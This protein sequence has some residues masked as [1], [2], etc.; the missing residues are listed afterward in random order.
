[1]AALTETEARARAA[2][3]AVDS[4]DVF[5]DLN[6]EAAEPVRSRSE[7]RFGCGEPGAATFAELTATAT[8]AVLNGHPVGPPED[9]RL[10]LPGLAAAN[11]LVVEAEV[12][13]DVLARFT[14]PDGGDGYL[15]FTGY[16]TLSPGLFCCFDQVDLTATTTLSLVLPAGWECLANG[17]VVGRP[18]AGEP[19]RWRFGP[20]AGTRPFDLT[21]AAG[22][23]TRAW[24]GAVPSA[25]AGGTVDMSIWC[26]RSLAGTVPGLE[27]FAGQ[28]RQ[29]LAYYERLLGVPCPYPK[30]DI[31][32]V[33]RLNAQAISIP[34]LMLVSENLLAR[35]A[36]PD[37]DFVAMICAHEVSL[38]WFGCHVS[39]AWWDDLWLDEAM[40]TYVALEAMAAAGTDSPWTA[41][42]YREEPRAYEA[43]ALPGRQPVSSPVATA[44]DALARPVPLTYSKGTAVVRQLAALIGDDA[45]RAGLADYMGRFGGG[46]ASLDDLVG[47]W[48]RASGRDLAGWAQEWLRTEG[49]STLRVATAVGADG[50]LAALAVEQDE[51]RTHR[52]G[53]GLYDQAGD[54]SLRRRR[55]I[56]AEVS[57]A[58][59]AVPVPAG[60]PVPAAIV[61]ND[62]DLTYAEIA[63]D[64]A[65]LEALAGAAME[66]GDPLTEAM[67]WNAAWRMVM[68]GAL[69]G[70][71]LAGLVTRRLAAAELPPAAGIE[72][73]L[74][75]AVTAADLY[76]EHDERLRARAAL[77]AACLT[78]ADAAAPGSP[79]QRALAAGFAASADSGD[80][81]ARARAW[82]DGT[83]SDGRGR[84]AGLDVDGDLRGRLLRTLAARGLA[85]DG[86]LDALAAADPVGGARNRVAGRA[87]RPDAAA[88]AQAWAVALGDADRRITEAAASAMWVPGQEALLAAYRDRYF[89]TALEVL[90]RRDIRSLRRLSRALFPVTLADPATLAATAAAAERG[91]LSDGLRL[92][93]REQEAI[94]RA[95]RAARAAP[96]RGWLPG[97]IHLARR[98]RRGRRPSSGG[99]CPAGRSRARARACR[100]APPARPRRPG[101]PA[102]SWP[103]SR[104]TGR[105]ARGRGTGTAASAW[106][107]RC[108]SGAGAR[109]T[110]PSPPRRWCGCPGPP[111][112]SCSIHP[113]R[114]RSAD[115]CHM[116]RARRRAHY[117][118]SCN[119]VSVPWPLVRKITSLDRSRP[120]A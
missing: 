103:R 85:A 68:A 58:R 76:T 113:G 63:F 9:G 36:D 92:V 42:C 20:V 27:R 55:V 43:D 73:L 67:G 23:Y 24:G 99:G 37:D 98:R 13:A 3:I 21:I 111:G 34:G 75:R 7:I 50:T 15:L 117:G 104:T 40:A 69:N 54:G 78:G 109:G 91:D 22:P 107:G 5:I 11:T 106:T 60:E 96:R 48:S 72:V 17:P 32:F 81:L 71:D 10:A 115:R 116:T 45:L 74:E 52:I 97:V 33:P 59:S 35:K 114:N 65:S 4:Y 8:S 18:P 88:K 118:R 80:Q 49:A 53:I 105:P 30:Y 6:P 26:R 83:V 62:G 86:E 41:F 82:L 61:P 16:P 25:R 64:P 84:P 89:D 120:G 2:L 1:M 90:D 110:R 29:A 39:S 102:A 12:A 77:A 51:P 94:L 93:L 47:C 119:A 31:G 44:A 87:A 100:P 19:G 79:V 112:R 14:D 101:A 28:A 66:V 57:G 95:L 56:G 38:L 70:A 108:R 46:T